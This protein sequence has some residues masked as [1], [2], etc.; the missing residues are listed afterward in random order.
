GGSVALAV[1][2]AASPPAA[3]KSARAVAIC[4]A[5]R[6]LRQRLVAALDADANLAVMGTV[7]DAAALALLFE[8]ARVDIAVVDAPATDRLMELTRTYPATA[9]VA[10]VDPAP[11]DGAVDALRAGAHALLS[12]AADDADVALTVRAIGRGLAVVPTD[13]L[14]AL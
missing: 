11:H 5:D 3:K 13:A 2:L 7:G 10:I 8:R 12:R 6:A 14:A 9:F 1:T 4:S